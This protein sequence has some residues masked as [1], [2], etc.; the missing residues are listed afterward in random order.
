[1]ESYKHNEMIEKYENECNNNQ[2]ICHKLI[3]NGISKPNQTGPPPMPPN[4]FSFQTKEQQNMHNNNNNN[5]NNNNINDNSENM[6]EFNPTSIL[7]KESHKKISCVLKSANLKITPLQSLYDKHADYL[8]WLKKSDKRK[9]KQKK[10]QNIEKQQEIL[11]HG[12]VEFNENKVE[13]SNANINGYDIQYI[14]ASGGNKA[15]EKQKQKQKQKGRDDSIEEEEEEL[16]EE[17]S[18]ES[19]ESESESQ[20][21]SESES[22]D[23]DSQGSSM[24][25]DESEEDSNESE[26][27]ESDESEGESDESDES[28]GGE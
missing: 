9:I 16:S 26:E 2:W 22:G 21:Q 6:N 28:G 4:G 27:G 3:V 25:E 10:L 8:L 19:D 24:E 23:D 15:K 13:N 5:N 7:R 18:G 17:E 14:Q 11:Y 20:S 12:W 1:M